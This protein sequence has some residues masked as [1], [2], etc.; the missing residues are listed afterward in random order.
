MTVESLHQPSVFNIVL[1]FYH[2]PLKPPD[3]PTVWYR[4]SHIEYIFIVLLILF[5]IH[6]YIGNYPTDLFTQLK[7]IMIFEKQMH[8]CPLTLKLGMRSFSTWSAGNLFNPGN[9]VFLSSNQS[10]WFHWKSQ[11]WFAKNQHNHTA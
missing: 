1:P 4:S 7:K 8:L 10:M 3:I 5:F 2:Y 6:S 11:Y 9:L